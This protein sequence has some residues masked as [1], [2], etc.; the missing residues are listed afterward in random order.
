MKHLHFKQLDSTQI[1]LKNNY[2][3]LI[4][5][6]KDLLITCDTQ[7]EGIGRGQNTWTKR[8]N[9]ISLSCTLVPNDCPS[10]TPLEVAVMCQQFFLPQKIK[11]KWPNDLFNSNREKVGGIIC[12]LVSPEMVLVGVGINLGQAEPLE[13]KNSSYQPGVLFPQ[14]EYSDGELV[15]LSKKM[16][17]HFLKNR[18]NSSRVKEIWENECLHLNQKVKIDETEGYFR[19]IQNDGQALLEVSGVINKIS[20][21]NLSLLSF[22]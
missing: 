16:Y 20:S 19:G 9:S 10:L 13:L 3:D 6:D 8:K 15:N 5:E 18:L 4:A 7:S 17:Q 2:Q 21:G 1:H 22:S 12:Q 14:K 11:F